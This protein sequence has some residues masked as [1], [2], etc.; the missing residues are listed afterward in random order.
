MANPSK[1]TARSDPES[2]RYDQPEDAPQELA[3][4]FRCVARFREYNGL[5]FPESC[6]LTFSW[7]E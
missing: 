4:E 7:A 6:F 5:P 3:I 1:S 2:R